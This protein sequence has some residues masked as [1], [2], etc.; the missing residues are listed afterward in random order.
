MRVVE[1][2]RSSAGHLAEESARAEAYLADV[3]ERLR[4]QGVQARTRVQVAG[5]AAEAILE[6]GAAQKSDLIAI[7]THGRGGLGRLLLGSVADR[8]LCGANS[9]VLVYR[10]GG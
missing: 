6:E 3:A 5:S 2:S 4:A 8:V 7:A 9:P 1:R 10:S